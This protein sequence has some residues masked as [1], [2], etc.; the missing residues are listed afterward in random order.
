MNVDFSR[1]LRPLFSPSRFKSIRG[2]RDGGKSW[3]VSQY[4]VEVGSASEAQRK[5]WGLW[6]PDGRP[7]FMVCFR[8]N[9][10]SIA[11]SVHRLL[12]Q[13]IHR[14]QLESMWAIGKASVSNHRTGAE[15]VFKGVHHNP[16][17][18]KSLEGASRAWGE[19]AQSISDDSWR[20]VIPTVRR[21]NSEITLTWNPKLETDA[22]WKRFVLHK[23]SN[24]AE[25][26]MNFS[27][28]PWASGVLREEREQMQ[29]DDPDEYAH[30]WLGQ[31]RRMTKGSIYG[32]QL[33]L[34]E[35]QGR[36]T[37]VPHKPALTVD[38]GFDLGDGDFTAIWFIQ[39][40]MGQHRVID[41]E[42]DRHKPLSHYLDLLAGK[43]YR[44]G[45]I[46]FPWDAASKIVVGSF[47]QTM[48]AKGFNVKVLPR[49][50]I[51]TGIDA[52]RE[53]LGS[54]WWDAE[55]CEHGLNRLRYYRYE[56]TARI[57]PTT[58]DQVMARTPVHDENSHGADAK[59]TWAMGIRL[60]AGTVARPSVEQGGPK[61]HVSAWS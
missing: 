18:I 39:S 28:N 53:A 10:N 16:D 1:V 14:L 9:M 47:E 21:P 57:D 22:T 3:G 20:Q 25:I 43:G 44:Y 49:Q 50:S 60:N 34:A 7:E 12:E 11:D 61:Q 19:E 5:E 29:R 54:C 13:T 41:Y 55:K 48:R 24:C 37:A 32:V 30:V 6:I 26:V 4:H 8:E 52:V 2:G 58:G 23:P 17:G 51:E 59:R 31:P 42:E 35:E 45:R 38:C 36:I 27:D 15:I 33:R 56:M 40:S 46:F